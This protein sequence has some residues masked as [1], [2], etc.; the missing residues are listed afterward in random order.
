[1][2]TL[3]PNHNVLI[4]Y[5][6]I[7]TQILLSHLEKLFILS[8]KVTFPERLVRCAGE[9]ITMTWTFPEKVT[10]VNFICGAEQYDG[11]IISA[12]FT[13]RAANTVCPSAIFPP[14]RFS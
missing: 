7:S 14:V 2:D 1:M 3:K 10:S 8:P 6:D 12:A 4:V 11:T 9:N 13:E 5:Y